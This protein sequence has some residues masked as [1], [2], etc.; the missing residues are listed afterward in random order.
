MF[1]DLDRFKAL[2]DAHG[3]EAGDLLLVEAA[4]RLKAC[5][6]EMDTVARFG[7]DEFVILL[8]N[9]D[10]DRDESTAQ[11][12]R[13]AANILAALGEPYRLA[14]PQEAGPPVWVQHRC[15]ASIGIVGFAPHHT[16]AH[17]ILKWADAAMY[18]AKG[19]GREA[20]RFHEEPDGAVGGERPFPADPVV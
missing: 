3:H 4:S 17:D 14:L 7:G 5:V 19:G 10:A 9:L 6:R 20:I 13:V 16:N 11:A 2:N 18:R 1:L 12:A 8:G 15:T